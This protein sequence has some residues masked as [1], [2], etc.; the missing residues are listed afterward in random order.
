MAEA[1]CLG[2]AL[3]RLPAAL[4]CEPGPTVIKGVQRG[5]IPPPDVRLPLLSVGKA[6][7]ADALERLSRLE[8]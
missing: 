8:E 4:F 1:R 2:H 7:V 6:T 5:L 3:A